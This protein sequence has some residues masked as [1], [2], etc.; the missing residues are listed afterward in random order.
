MESIPRAVIEKKSIDWR[1]HDD[2]HDDDDDTQAI[3]LAPW[4]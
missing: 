1:I 4:I 3:A 2:D